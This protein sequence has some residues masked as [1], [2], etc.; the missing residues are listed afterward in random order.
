MGQTG[1]R[2]QD[3][4]AESQAETCS[5]GRVPSRALVEPFLACTQP[6]PP[7]SLPLS[8]QWSAEPCPLCLP[9]STSAWPSPC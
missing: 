1:S 9:S 8:T 3:L 2:G 4:S 5:L 6:G 7:L